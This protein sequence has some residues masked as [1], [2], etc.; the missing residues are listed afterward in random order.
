VFPI[1]SP[2]GALNSI[3]KPKFVGSLKFNEEDEKLSINKFI[4]YYENEEK[5]YPPSEV[6][7]M[8]KSEAIFLT[9][10]DE[11][12]EEFFK[13]HNIKVRFTNICKF[14]A[15]EGNIT[16]INS[17]SS[18]NYN[19]QLICRQCAL[20]TI[21]RELELQGYNKKVFRN[22]KALLDKTND[23][24]Q[25]VKVIDHKFDP[26]KNPN[27]TLF[28]TIKVDNNLK[29]PDIE[30]KRLKIPEDFK[31]VL[32]DNGNEKLLPVQILA[33]KEG[34]LKG[35]NILAVSATGSGKTLIGEI[36]GI[37][38]AL[39]GKKFIFL[40]PLVA[41]ANQKYRDFKRKYE[42]LGLK[43]AIKVGMNRVK[44][45]GELNFKNSD[46][47]DADIIVGTYEGIDFLLRSG[48][49]KDLEELGVILIDE[50][51]TLDDEDRG[52]RLNG[53]IKRV[54]KL[55]PK[56][57]TIALS[58]T[59]KNPKYLANLL[60]ANLVEY[61]PRPVPIERHLIYTRN[62]SDKKI[63]IRK[64]IVKEFNTISS[65]GF[66]GQTII[67]T[68]SRR[69]THQLSNYLSNKGLNVKA[70]HAGLSYFKK[71]KIEKDFDEGKIA[72]VVTTAAL[73]A[74]VDFPASQ[75][76]FDSLLMGNSWISPNEFS[77]MLGRAG[78]PSYHDIGKIFLLPEVGNSFDGESEEL[79]A[80]NLLESDVE[81]V[82]ID[83]TYEDALEEILSD[84]SSFTVK[85]SQ[86]LKDFYKNT[87][88]PVS[89]DLAI[90]ELVDKSLIKYE[91]S[92]LKVTTYGRAVA[93]SFLKVD[94]AEFIK[95]SLKNKNYL[96]NILKSQ[97]NSYE[98]NILNKLNDKN[99]KNNLNTNYLKVKFIAMELGL[100]EN[101]YL[102]P[103][104][105][106]KLA[107]ALK[108]N[109][110]SRLFA[111]STLDI[112]SSGESISKLDSKFQDAL[113]KLQIDFLKCLCEE[114]PFCTC[115]QRGI[116]EMIIEERLKGFDPIDISDKLFKD[117]QIQIY[118]GDIFS[119]LDT[120]LR[121]LDAVKRI[122]DS[123][124]MK[125]ISK[126][127]K[128]LIKKIEKP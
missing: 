113:L 1:G 78:R 47:K 87:Q 75:V 56:T 92:K 111:E 93:M 17:K 55:F 8:F 86:E 94:E 57:Q 118:P 104:I 32:I 13:S 34:V 124:K 52:I 80:L 69:K 40:T 112:I 119:W 29:I 128:N 116:S 105:H 84:I 5:L 121:N 7:R 101:A 54:K 63:T 82:H 88:L 61:S 28:D 24:E 62:D 83:Y 41:L 22:F 89:T 50:I 65:K 58:A 2:K 79:V 125:N 98:I 43:V 42:K 20:N 33:I 11:K 127:A 106:S 66:K 26:L 48:N 23:L 3:R 16:I 96:K 39:K 53:L 72:A 120:Y 77:Q 10:K 71:E 27:L 109:I 114:K 123:F 108:M 38:Q 12:L 67:F 30:M 49:Y 6:L 25:V 44:A 46:I 97:S 9:E 37:P 76:I 103:L 126:E 14:C 19:N 81:K 73:A 95:K 102:S 70:Y 100:I 91:S 18:Y 4:A 117:Y 51:H 107:G 60:N 21:K 90:D 45:K 64:L 115:L 15:N 59:V 122:A 110:S 36:A 68:N 31:N 99:K 35:E 74:G 85:N